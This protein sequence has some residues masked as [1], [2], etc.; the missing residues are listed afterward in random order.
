[1]SFGNERQVRYQTRLLGFRDE[2]SDPKTEVKVNFTNLSAFLTPKTYTFEVRAVNESGVWSETPVRYPFEVK[3]PWW[4]TWWA[5][6]GYLAIFAIGVFVVDRVQRSRLIRKEREAAELRETKLKAEAAE[7]QAEALRAENELKATELE[8]ARELEKAYHELKS[9]QKRLIQSEKMASL[10]RL[11]T[12]IAHE[13]KNPLNFIN[14]FAELSKDLVDELQSAL[15]SKDTDEIEFIT[16]NLKFNTRKIEEHGKRADSIVR[17]MMQHSRSGN[18]NFE[19]TEVNE[20]VKTYSNLAY[21]SKVAENS[22]VDINIATD[23]EPGLPEIVI[24]S[25]QIGQ[26]LQNII[27]NALDAVLEHRKKQDGDYQPQISIKTRSRDGDIEIEI[28]DN[29][30]GIPESVK[31]KIF[32]PFFTTKPTGE[33]TGLGLSISYDI[34]TQ[35]H[36]GGIR[37]ENVPEGGARFVISFPVSEVHKGSK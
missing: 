8:K 18:L 31:E 13:I 5:A 1:M 21:Q 10:G 22:K 30:P 3:P 9:T 23:L 15:D 25:Q 27:E 7:A 33:G 19:P 12:G 4:L 32:E 16:K 2:W 36:D 24:N 14:N 35:I 20:L 28:A 29:G 26:V 34:V 11:S 6:L 37:V 17:S